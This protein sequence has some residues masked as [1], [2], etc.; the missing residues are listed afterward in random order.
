MHESSQTTRMMQTPC[1]CK[2]HATT[3]VRGQAV[4]PRAQRIYRTLHSIDLRKGGIDIVQSAH[5]GLG[6]SCAERRRPIASCQR[7][8]VTDHRESH[9]ASSTQRDGWS[10]EGIAASL[11][12]L[13]LGCGPA[14]ADAEAK[15]NPT[16]GSDS[17]K[18]IAGVFY[19][20]LLAVFAYRLLTRRAKKFREERLASAP[21]EEQAAA[22]AAREED[23]KVVT[24]L[25]SLWSAIRLGVFAYLLFQLSSGVDGYFEGQALPD[26]LTARNITITLRTVVRGLS[27]LLTFL[28]AANTIGLAALTVQLLINPE[29]GSQPSVVKATKTTKDITPGGSDPT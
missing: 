15:Y 1:C 8:A 9:E 11:W 12:A 23:E 18:S 4:H 20:G 27:Y 10:Q 25:R 19:A 22:Q 28:F 24:P 7:K 17:V 5:L 21:A 29:A 2:V 6:G 26:Q 14:F 16:K 13:L 3:A